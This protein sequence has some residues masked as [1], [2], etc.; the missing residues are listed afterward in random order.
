M[1][2]DFIIIDDDVLV[3]LTWEITAKKV[4]KKILTLTHPEEFF[5]ISKDLDK[6]IPI[7]IDSNLGDQILGQDVA[8]EIYA[9]GFVQIY[10]AT[11]YSVSDFD[12][13][14]WIAGIVGKDP[15]F[16]AFARSGSD[17]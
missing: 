12:P 16:E 17:F 14:P 4:G 13:M 1:K 7:Y 6:T 8:K 9:L 2:P 10:L 15:P 3:Q 11:G 5:L